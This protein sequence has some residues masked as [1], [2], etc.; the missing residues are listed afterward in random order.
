LE[1]GDAWRSD[2]PSHEAAAATG[3]RVVVI[4]LGLV[5]ALLATTVI[6][7]AAFL[8]FQERLYPADGVVTF[9]DQPLEGATVSFMPTWQYGIVATGTT[10]VQGRFTLYSNGRPG[11]A[12]GKYRVS[13]RAVAEREDEVYVDKTAPEEEQLRVMKH[14]MMR[15][16]R[17]TEFRVPQHYASP[18][19]SGLTAEVRAFGENHFPFELN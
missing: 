12:R 13:V 6:A 5:C 14:L 11:A 8:R 3:R 18:H 17:V 15:E 9:Q 19:E 10:D 2:Q 7:V 1:S 4:V 16:K